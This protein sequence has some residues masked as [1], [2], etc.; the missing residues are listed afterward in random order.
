MRLGPDGD[1]VVGRPRK[2]WCDLLAVS[3]GWN[4]TVH[5]HAQSGGVPRYDE[6]KLCFVPG[7]PVQAERSAGACSGGFTLR[8]CLNEGLVAGA[9]AAHAAGFGDRRPFDTSA[10]DCRYRRGTIEGRVWVVPSRAPLGHGAKQ[11]VDLQTD[12]TADDIAI[13]ALEGYDSIEHVKRYTTLGMGSDQGKLSSA[14]GIGVLASVLGTDPPSVGTTTFRPPYTPV[15]FG[16]IAGRDLGPLFDP[17]RKTSIHPWHEDAGAEF[18][19]VGQWKRPWY[20]PR[21]GES[22]HETVTRE[23]LA[24]GNSVGVM[25]ASTLGKIDVRGPDASVFLNRV[26]TNAWRQLAI[27]RC[28]YGFMLKEDGMLLDDGVTARLAADHYYMHTTTGGA[29]N[30]MAWLERWLQTEWPDLKVYL[31][32]I[33]DQWATVSV[34]GPDSRKVVTKLCNDIDFSREAFPFMS[35][36]EGTVAGIPARVFRVSFVGELSFEINVN[37]NYG[38]YVWEGVMEAGREFDIT[39]FGTEAMHILRAQKGYII[40]G[41]DTDGS[42]TPVDL[43]MEWIISKRKKDFLGKRSLFREDT[44]RTD[45]KQLIGLFTDDPTEVLPEGAQIVD[46]PKSPIPMPML[47]HVTSSYMSPALGRSFAMGYIKGGHSRMGDRVYVALMDGRK[48]AAV[49]TSTPFYDPEGERQNV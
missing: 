2:L 30:V 25:D 6:A 21:P 49:I 43:G 26:Y 1:S 33:T 27:G 19:N 46:D 17:V 4:P 47:G 24:V 23:C 18:E 34:N 45:R 12:T 42:M 38:R 15:T 5:L 37:A 35:F 22:F 39:P 41:Q 3:G 10:G 44:A 31:T 48:P 11:F 8:E 14:N 28:R 36:R 20:F 16:A 32:S 13:A 40:S 9:A 7:E 29:A